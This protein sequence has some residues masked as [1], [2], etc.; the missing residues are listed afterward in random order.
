MVAKTYKIIWTDEA[1]KDLKDIFDF[2]KIQSVQSAKNVIS[3]IKNI[4]KTIR[5]SNQNKQEYYNDRY[6][7][8][9]IRN[10]K[11]LYRISDSKNELIIAAVF[12]T[13]QNPEKI[14][15]ID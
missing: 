8:I 12:H 5:F 15:E 4:S 11:I 2:I 1:K 6:Q 14:S 7:R 3:D 10:Y 9:I 13:S